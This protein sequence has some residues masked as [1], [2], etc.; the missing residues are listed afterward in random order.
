[1]KT[2]N[3]ANKIQEQF[4]LVA[5]EYDENRKKFIPCFDAFYDDAT[6]FISKS[7]RTP[8]RI[9]DLGAG[10]GILSAFYFKHFGDAEFLLIDVADEML[11]VARKR[12]LGA[13]NVKFMVSDYAKNF[14]FRACNGENFDLIISALSI[15]HL[16]DDEKQ[17]L[18]LRIYDALPNGGV[19]VN[20]D[21]FCAESLEINKNFTTYWENKIF[22]SGLSENDIAKWKERQKL[23]RE[24]SVG[25][26]IKMIKAG[27]FENAEC[28]FLCQKF[29]V[30]VGMKK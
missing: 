12:F 5:K 22:S 20:Y 13:N 25:Q 24:C 17:K 29:A 26:E 4:N 9:L 3:E 11:A 23:D 16:E 28:I 18:F 21:Q 6:D 2:I 1:M 14:D 15:H 27:G 7:I 19:F 30:I 8:K 10:T